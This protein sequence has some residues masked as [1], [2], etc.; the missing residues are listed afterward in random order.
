MASRWFYQVA[1]REV[2]PVTFQQLAARIRG[3]K[4]SEDA[5]VRREKTKDWVPCRQVIGLL[6]AAGRAPTE[7]VPPEPPEKPRPKPTPREPKKA[8]PTVGRL[9]GLDR[10]YLAWAAGAMIVV[11]VGGVCGW[12]ALAHRTPRFPEP[13]WGAARPGGDHLRAVLRLERPEACS[14][15]GLEVW[16]PSLVPGLEKVDNAFSPCLSPD[17]RTIIFSQWSLSEDGDDLAGA[18]LM[19]ATREDVSLPF[20]KPE[21]METTVTADVEVRPALSP[22]GLELIFQRSDWRPR[23]FRCTRET[24]F[25]EFGEPV[26]WEVPKLET[27]GRLLTRPQFLDHRRVS[28]AFSDPESDTRSIMVTER[29]DRDNSFDSVREIPFA[30]VWPIYYITGDELRAYCGQPDG[31]W[32]GFRRNDRDKFGHCVRVVGADVCGPVD[33]PL[34][35]T[36]QEDVI[37]YCSP[38][39]GK[40]IK[41]GGK[42]WM[43][44]F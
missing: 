2:G 23:L 17:L 12:W 24:V 33:G 35:V 11:V 16:E 8:R 5:S 13:Q 29:A 43:F 37:F 39:R 7:T 9:R 1:G 32:V 27:A 34:W 31:L 25:V 19:I 21:L 3:G 20:G 44:R 30:N 36:P 41:V 14:V 40:E 38:G 15:P 6:R 42:I 28:F 10:R 26:R 4:L 22:D 18:D